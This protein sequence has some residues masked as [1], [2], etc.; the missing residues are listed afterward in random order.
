MGKKSA[1]KNTTPKVIRAEIVA[2]SNG[3]VLEGGS[4]R[5]H[6]ACSS[7]ML[8]GLLCNAVKMY[9]V[10]RQ[11]RELL[12]IM[13]DVQ[14]HPLFVA[15]LENSLARYKITSYMY[16]LRI[17]GFGIAYWYMALARRKRTLLALNVAIAIAIFDFLRSLIQGK[18]RG[19]WMQLT[20]L[21]LDTVYLRQILRNRSEDPG[22][23][24][25]QQLRKHLAYIQ[26]LTANNKWFCSR[27]L[28]ADLNGG[29]QE[30]KQ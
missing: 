3:E 9:F 22:M 26:S 2:I 23:W 16:C 6:W 13:N 15:S 29:N 25:V 19:F 12:D 10:P 11:R 21:I 30:L 27:G 8:F 20:F 28:A 7:V 18:A 24:Y 5:L 17:F 4:R 14:H 1:K